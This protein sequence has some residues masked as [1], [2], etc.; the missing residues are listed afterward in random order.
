M[1]NSFLTCGPIRKQVKASLLTPALVYY[2]TESLKSYNKEIHRVLRQ[3]KSGSSVS[4]SV[5]SFKCSYTS[6]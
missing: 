2:F 6:Y 5:M 4:N 1:Q 3:V